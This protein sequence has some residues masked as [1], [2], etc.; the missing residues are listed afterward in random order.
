MTEVASGYDR[1]NLEKYYTP[2]WA[3][4]AVVPHMNICSY[5]H[6]YDPAAG[7][8]AVLRAAWNMGHI[9]HGGDIEPDASGIEQ[10]DFLIDYR[11]RKVVLT[12]PPFGQQGALAC[13]FIRHALKVTEANRGKVAMLLRADFDSASGRADIF[14][15]HPAFYMRGVMLRRIKWTN[16]VQVPGKGP[17]TNHTW[18]VWDWSKP[19][20]AEPVVRYIV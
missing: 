19:A 13:K 11:L 4:R 12:N 1:M 6:I 3:I 10:V 20:N 16:V 17:S 7:D 15:D 18:F 5:D 9:A 8:G 2:E 14:R